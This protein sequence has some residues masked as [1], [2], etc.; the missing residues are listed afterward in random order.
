[1][2]IA[3]KKLSTIICTIMIIVG[4][5]IDCA[6][7]FVGLGIAG[8]SSSDACCCRMSSAPIHLAAVGGHLSCLE[9]LLTRNADVNAQTG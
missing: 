8:I 1:M 9:L 4:G 5:E 2:L 3:R 7:L 6:W